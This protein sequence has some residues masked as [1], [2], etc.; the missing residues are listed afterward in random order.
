MVFL[1]AWGC[2]SMGYTLGVVFVCC[3]ECQSFMAFCTDTLML[4]YYAVSIWLLSFCKLFADIAVILIFL[5][6]L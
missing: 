2:I 1:Q 6:A 4:R 3:T 5:G